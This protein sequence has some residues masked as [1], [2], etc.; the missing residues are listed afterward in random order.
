MS[1]AAPARFRA[2]RCSPPRALGDALSCPA[3]AESFPALEAFFSSVLITLCKAFFP[4]LVETTRRVSSPQPMMLLLQNC[5]NLLSSVRT[6]RLGIGGGQGAS[7]RVLCVA[8]G[9]STG[10]QWPVSGFHA[11]TAGRI[12]AQ[13]QVISSAEPL[14]NRRSLWL[15]VAYPFFLLLRT[16]FLSLFLH[17]FRNENVLRKFFRRENSRED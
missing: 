16:C 11:E 8:L 1:Q 9:A 6:A 2:L 5:Q 15:L 17:N 12:P 4:S 10:R 13:E 7:H 14:M 3:P